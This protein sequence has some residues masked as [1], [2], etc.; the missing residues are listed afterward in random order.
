[1]AANPYWKRP[2]T[3]FSRFSARLIIFVGFCVLGGPSYAAVKI[4]HW[5]TEK[6]ARVYF[7]E[8]HDLPLLDVNVEFSAGSSRDQP[9]KSGLA[10]LTRHMLASGAGGLSEDDI[11]KRLADVG[12]QLSGSFDMDR[13]GL[14]LR[15]LSHPRERD[16]ALGILAKILQSPDFPAEILTREKARII[17][18]LKE[19]ETQPDSIAQ[20]AFYK[21]IYGAHPYALQTAGEI[22]T[23]EQL[24]RAD[25]QAF[26]ARHFNA[27]HAVV[28]IIGDI[29]R[30]QAEGI[31]KNLTDNL[32]VASTAVEALPEIKIK[33]QGKL[34]KIAH[35]ATQSHVLMGMPGLRRGDPDYFPLYVGNYI[36]GGGGF[37]SRLI[38]E[39]RQQKGLAYS[40]YSYFSPMRQEGPF[41]IGL[42]T[43]K[44]Q[45]DEAL[46]IVQTTLR[47]FITQGPGAQ[48]LKEAK[49]NLIGGFALRLDSNKKILEYLAVIGFYQ[50]P[51]TYL[52][53]FT[54]KIENVTSAQIK[55]A[56]GKRI[57]P[58]SLDT[59]IVG[60]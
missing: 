17:A 12:A 54:G 37:V 11:S 16:E 47:K 46:A 22:N 33:S 44:S 40:V 36:L 57:K 48:E 56:F 27:Q 20:K 8:N 25:L 38:E 53:D 4:Q 3:K 45:T 5:T 21:E 31:A 6:G 10:N 18:G 32:P 39:V 24:T 29:T 43:Q 51:L 26:Y 15:T 9:A 13:S 2:A 52:D 35:P 58:E 34:I 28:A 30:G 7:V 19:A 59:V 14:T 49:Q 50:L 60:L 42:Q 41:V 23:V 1:M 55:N